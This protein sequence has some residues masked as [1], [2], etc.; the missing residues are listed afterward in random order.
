LIFKYA[1]NAI[2][3]PHALG[4]TNLGLRGFSPW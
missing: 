1:S 4:T 2:A 3:R